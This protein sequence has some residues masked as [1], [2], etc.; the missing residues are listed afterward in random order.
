MPRSRDRSRAPT[1]SRTSGPG[2]DPDRTSAL[3]RT[4]WER[5]E[6]G[7]RSWRTATPALTA[8]TPPAAPRAYFH[9]RGSPA[10]GDETDVGE[11]PPGPT[12]AELAEA[13]RVFAG[14]VRAR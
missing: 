3:A 2:I 5:R 10:R 13:G 7:E 11:G 4:D 6:G 14:A 1:C 9:G 12:G 8:A